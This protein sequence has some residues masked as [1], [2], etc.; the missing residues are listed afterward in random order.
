[1]GF[2]S[3]VTPERGF[4][5]LSPVSVPVYIDV[6]WTPLLTR[7]G[8]QPS[9]VL[10]ISFFGPV[11]TDLGILLGNIHAMGVGAAILKRP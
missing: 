6:S 1:M 9:D 7:C 5:M 2:V 8:H 10:G 11:T 3:R 4:T